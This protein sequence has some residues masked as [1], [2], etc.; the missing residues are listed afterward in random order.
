MHMEFPAHH[1]RP[2]T[3]PP[4]TGAGAV[5]IAAFTLWLTAEILSN[6]PRPKHAAHSANAQKTFAIAVSVATERHGDGSDDEQVQEKQDPLALSS[7]ASQEE[8]DAFM[9]R[10]PRDVR[11]LPDGTD[12]PIGGDPIWMTI[13]NE[14]GFVKVPMG[15]ME[16]DGGKQVLKIGDRCFVVKYLKLTHPGKNWVL[17]ATVSKAEKCAE[18]IANTGELTL[19]VLGTLSDTTVMP[20]HMIERNVRELCSENVAAGAILCPTLVEPR[21]FYYQYIGDQPIDPVDIVDEKMRIKDIHAD[22][23][24][25]Q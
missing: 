12:L 15:Y 23:M 17:R 6:P 22:M 4:K 18:G 24:K 16:T 19:P 2:E 1:E 7:N 14:K 21:L 25:E 13:H 20:F 3:I 10:E 8:V 5:S 9:R 11:V